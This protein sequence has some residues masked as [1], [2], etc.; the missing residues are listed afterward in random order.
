MTR[1]AI[2]QQILA[3]SLWAAGIV[4]WS[5]SAAQAFTI[6]SGPT[7]VVYITSATVSWGTDVP[8]G[9]GFL[10]GSGSLTSRTPAD[11]APTTL[12]SVQL[13]GLDANTTYTGKPLTDSFQQS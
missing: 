4:L 2:S 13:T 12:H 3:R 1:N 8:V 11:S 9:T 5:L 6:S 10:Y 7:A